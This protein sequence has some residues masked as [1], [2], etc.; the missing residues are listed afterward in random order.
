MRHCAV[1][2]GHCVARI[3]EW[4]SGN[5]LQ[6]LVLPHPAP[7][8]LPPKQNS[9]LDVASNF[10][11]FFFLFHFQGLNRRPKACSLDFLWTG[12][13]PDP[14]P[15]LRGTPLAFL[16]KISSDIVIFIR[17]DCDIVIRCEA[18]TSISSQEEWTII[19]PSRYQLSMVSC[20]VGVKIQETRWKYLFCNFPNSNQ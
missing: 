10:S 12:G 2:P 19:I 6:G 15:L 4:I 9:L 14:K 16:P 18:N 17:I 7:A 11:D 13:V 3:I 5:K 8:Q 20:F 1:T